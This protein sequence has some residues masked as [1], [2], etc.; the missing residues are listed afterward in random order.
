MKALFT[1]MNGTVAPAVATYFKEKGYEIISYD[2]NSISTINVD[3]IDQFIQKAKIDM[4]LH[5][6]MGS[7]EWTAMLAT[8]CK[9]RS[10]P[11]VFISTVSVFSN[12]NRGPYTVDS[13]PDASDEYGSYKRKSE[14]IVMLNN[15]QAY[16]IRL[17]WQIGNS[18]GKNQMI[19][20]LYQ[21]M[22]KQGFI[23][24]SSLWYP[25]VSFLEDSASAIYQIIKNLPAGL[26]HVN[27]NESYTFFDIVTRLTR[28]YPEFVVKE[29]KEFDADHRM[30]DGRVHI[31]TL[32]DIFND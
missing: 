29:N 24:A 2:R 13:I 15:P 28:I 8:V 30:V 6:A 27:S 20:F 14:Q 10:I 7:F 5:F 9:K 4:L 32:K 17:G 19:D 16:I 23:S 11:F 1:G 12:Q 18:R 3:E 25:S 22:D 21:Q 31:K 26:Y